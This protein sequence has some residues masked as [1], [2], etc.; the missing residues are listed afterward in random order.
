MT[1]V[2]VTFIVRELSIKLLNIYCIHFYSETL[3]F[4][5]VCFGSRTEHVSALFGDTSKVSPM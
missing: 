1:I 5:P 3:Y 2:A 4:P